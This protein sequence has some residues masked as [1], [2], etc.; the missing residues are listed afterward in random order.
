MLGVADGQVPLEGEHSVQKNGAGAKEKRHDLFS[1][2]FCRNKHKWK[3]L[4]MTFGKTIL[5]RCSLK[6]SEPELA[7]LHLKPFVKL[8]LLISVYIAICQN[9]VCDNDTLSQALM[10]A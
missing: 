3:C 7:A 1:H 10:N 8:S 5:R 4:V 6:S 2:F 9:D